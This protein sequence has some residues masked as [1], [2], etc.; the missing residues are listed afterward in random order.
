[1][2]GVTEAFDPKTEGENYT[3]T[4]MR[5]SNGATATLEMGGV[6]GARYGPEPW[7]VSQL[8]PSLKLATERQERE[9]ERERERERERDCTANPR[10]LSI[11]FAVSI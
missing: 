8:N 7:C 1:M 4:L 10:L 3:R 9:G 5:F 2:A 11:R 6:P